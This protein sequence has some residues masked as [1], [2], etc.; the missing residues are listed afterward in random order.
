MRILLVGSNY[1]WSIENYFIKYFSEMGLKIELFPAQTQFYNYYYS[2]L[3]NKIKFRLGLSRIINNINKELLVHINSFQPK[4]I[5]IFK[6]ME[7]L[8]KTLK[9]LKK[10]SVVLVNYNPDNPF[11]FSGKG[12]GNKNLINGL[13]LFDIHFTYSVT[14]K[15]ELIKKTNS[16]VYLLPFGYDID[17]NLFPSIHCQNEVIKTCFLGNPDK[18]RVF[19][20]KQLADFGIELDLY[21]HNWNKYI[22]H[23]KIKIFEPVYENEFWKTLY[24]YRVQLN[25]MRRH[26]LDSHNMRSFEIPAVGGIQLAP[27]TKEHQLFFEEN[28]EIFLYKNLGECLEKINYLLSLSTDN[29]NKIR[30]SARSRCIIS[31]YS[32]KD[33]TEHLVKFFESIE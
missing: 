20:I 23:D 19:F 33:R 28:K 12:S 7:I 29:A 14:I 3:I 27:F 30:Q 13:N 15:R 4:I 2:S 22:N 17:N 21:G 32:Y 11:I 5:F 10:S 9:T 1:S 6:G 16:K 18:E 8:P 26:N 31:K 24:K 25:I